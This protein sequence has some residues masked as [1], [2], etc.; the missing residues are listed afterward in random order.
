MQN[1]DAMP[2]YLAEK[3]RYWSNLGHWIIGGMLA[4][5]GVLA[6]L[7]I[8][9]VL[10][11]GWVYAWPGVLALAGLVL[12]LGILSHGDEKYGRELVL[13]DPQHRQH[14]IM[15]G[16]IFLGGVAEIVALAAGI[17]F[18]RYAWPLALGAVGVIF[19]IHP[20]HGT[21][22]AAVKAVRIHRILG[23]TF[24]LAGLARLIAVVTGAYSGLFGF[25]WIILVL[26]AAAQLIFY[27]EPEGAYE[28][29]SH[30]E[31][32]S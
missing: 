30:S 18:V 14:L 7:E 8:L 2:P 9:G 24:I 12:P 4:I 32:G 27:R 15:G 21:D 6:L 1:L 19:L 23:G 10:T 31:H 13:A 22:A 25:A 29:G 28:A 20:Q 5:V 17:G 26:V 3:M 11:G 16:I